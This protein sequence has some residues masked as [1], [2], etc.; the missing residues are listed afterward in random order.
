MDKVKLLNIEIDNFTMKEFL[1]ELR[2]GVV[3]TPNVDHMI[4]LQHDRD[5]YELYQRAEYVVLDSKILYRALKYLGTPV[6]EVIAGSD[7]FPA[8][9]RHHA[10]NENI[11]IFLLGA[12]PGVGKQAMENINEK[13]GREIV[14]GWFSPEFGFEKDAE[15]LQ[16]VVDIVNSS[17]ANVLAVGLG[18]PKQEKWIFSNRDKLKGIRIFLAIGATIDFEAGNV[19]RAPEFFR[20]NSLEWLYRM[21]AQP[22]RLIKRYLVDDLPIFRLVYKQKKGSYKNPFAE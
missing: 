6:K 9:Y 3:I 5:F 1:E 8:F 19:K 12:G 10:G 7:L 13:V 16:E 18:A 17:E 22:R 14:T 2:E 21:F 11:R 15:K 20:N 4:K